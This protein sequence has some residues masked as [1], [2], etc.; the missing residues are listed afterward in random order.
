MDVEISSLV[1][2]SSKLIRIKAIASMHL[3]LFIIHGLRDIMHGPLSSAR[4][5]L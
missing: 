1:V 4:E 3:L 2:C 5:I